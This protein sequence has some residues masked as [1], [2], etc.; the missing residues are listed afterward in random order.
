MKTGAVIA[1][2]GMSTRMKQPKQLMKI[3]GRTMA[4]QTVET[5]RRAGVSEIVMVTGYRGEEVERE[6]GHLAVTFLRN[7]SYETT[8]MFDSVKIGFRYLENRCDRLLFCPVDVPLFT[9]H[10]V[11]LLLEQTEDVV[12]PVYQGKKGHPVFINGALIPGILE[13]PGDGG[14]KGALDSLTWATRGF[15]LVEDEAVVLDADTK[16]E[17]ETLT[18]L[19]DSRTKVWGVRG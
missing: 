17:F 18:E 11:A 3:G 15:V 16:E 10:T 12:W 9:E 8:Q 7:D 4:E 14:L 2:A 13:Y 5:F 1:A 6:L 19:Y